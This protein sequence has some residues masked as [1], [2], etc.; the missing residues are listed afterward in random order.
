[1]WKCE[2]HTEQTKPILIHISYMFTTVSSIISLTISNSPKWNLPFSVGSS[3]ILYSSSL[4]YACYALVSS[5]FSSWFD[6]SK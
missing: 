6:Q 5:F 1:L 3:K 4:S 2:L